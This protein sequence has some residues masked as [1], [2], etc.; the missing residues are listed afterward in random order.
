MEQLKGTG[1]ALITPFTDDGAIDHPALARLVDFVV[2]GAIDYLVALGTTAESATLNKEEKEEV[3]RVVLKANAG[4]LPVVLGIGGN[5]T[6]SI[7]ESLTTTDLSGICA[8]LSVSPYYNRP[9]QEGIYQHFATLAQHSSKPLILYNVPGRTASNMEPSTVVRL[10]SDFENIVAIKEAKGDIDQAMR[11]LK[12]RPEGFLVISGDDM[13]TLPMT[14]AGGDGVISVIGQAF[15]QEFSQMVRAAMEGDM[16]KARKLHYDLMPA[17]D[18]AFE[19]GNP[20]GIKAFLRQ[21]GICGPKVRLPLVE[22]STSLND[23][24]SSF[25]KDFLVYQ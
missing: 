5:H 23:R 16:T 11:L 8:V 4:R 2:E 6:Q 24:I 18:L 9:T 12:D 25:T 1:V 13:V 19:E 20:S 17:I 15:P 22:A 10:A 3:L 7:V 14:L 21:L